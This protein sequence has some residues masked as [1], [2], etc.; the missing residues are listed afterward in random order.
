SSVLP[1]YPLAYPPNSFSGQDAINPE[2]LDHFYKDAARGALPNIAII[3]PDF[4]AND[5]HPPH[6]LALCEAFVASVYRALAES[7]QW[8]RSLLLVL[9]DE[10][11]G[12]YDHV[13]PPETDDPNPE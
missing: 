2:T 5:G 7:P 6:D 12:F 1:G 11:G 9:F 4:E 3:D 13:P 10:H 8:P